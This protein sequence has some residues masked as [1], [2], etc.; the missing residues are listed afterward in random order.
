MAKRFQVPV[1]LFKPRQ[2]YEIPTPFDPA[3][4]K[5]T[6]KALGVKLPEAFVEVL[7]ERNGGPLRL[8][9]FTMKTKP[10]RKMDSIS[11]RNYHV[12]SLSGIHPTHAD[13]LTQRTETARGWEVEQ[14][15]F[16]LDGD[17]H[18]WLCLDYRECGPRGEP[19]ITHWEQGDPRIDAPDPSNPTCRVADSFEELILGLRRAPDDYEPATISLDGEE[20]LPPRLGKILTSLGCKKHEYVGV[21]SKTPL[22]RTWTWDKYKNFV[23]GLPVWLTLEQNKTLGFAPKFDQRPEGH[24]MLRVSVTPKQAEKCLAE[25]MAALGPKATLFQSVI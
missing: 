10:P 23:R 24:P 9:T 17:G 5:R 6:E 16:P 3:E 7:K 11:G 12:G 18:Y 20:V 8:T 21:K 15:L 19:G 13:G 1:D 14:G 22:P 4:L 2:Q 25:V